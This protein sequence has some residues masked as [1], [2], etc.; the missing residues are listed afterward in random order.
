MT[1]FPTF[2]V[3]GERSVLLEWSSGIDLQTHKEVL[4]YS[5]HLGAKYSAYLEDVVPTYHSVALFIRPS[6]NIREFISRLRIEVEHVSEEKKVTKHLISLPVCY[7]EEFGL[8]IREMARSKNLTI[9]Q[10]IALHT[11]PTYQVYF[12]GFLPGFP[13]LGGLDPILSMNR[14]PRPRAV[15][16]KGSV[17]IGGSQTGIYPQ[18]S[19]G[20]W[21][22][23]GRTPLELFEPLAK[24]P[25]RINAGDRL[26]FEAITRDE[27]ELIRVE[28]KT[29]T[30]KW[31][32]EEIND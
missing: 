13:Y 17:G 5:H 26:K 23:I 29:G 22:I 11:A 21:N 4:T 25:T 1:S 2:Q 6:V 10:L 24:I 9:D 16:E 14:K 8:D 12:I 7:D 15:I 19:P 28:L 18:S 27:Y 31:R 30:F 20:G 32:K 3:F